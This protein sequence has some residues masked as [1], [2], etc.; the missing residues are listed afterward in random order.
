MNIRRRRPIEMRCAAILANLWNV[1][2][3]EKPIGCS[4]IGSSEACMLGGM[5]ALWRWRARR[6]AAGKPIDK[7]NLVCGP[8]QICWHKFCRYWDIEMRE[9]P[10]AP[11]KWKMDV[12]RMLEQV[13]ENTI[14]VVPTFGVTYT[15]AYEFPADIAK[16]LD[17]YEAKTGINIDI[18]VDGAS[19]AFLAPFCAPDI[20]FDFR[21]PRV[22]SISTSG[23]KYGLAPLGCGWVVWRDTSELPEGLIF[24]VNYLGGEI[25]NFA[26][27]FSRPAG[28]IICQYYDFIRLGKEGYTNIH[29]Q[30]YDV[31]QYISSE[32]AKLG[33]YEFICTGRSQGR[34]PRRL[35]L[36]QGRAKD[37]LHPLRPFRQAQDAWLAGTCLHAARGLPGYG[38][39]ARDGSPGLLQG[40]GGPLPGRLQAHDRFLRETPGHLADDR[41]RR[42]LLPPFLMEEAS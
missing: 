15:G 30:A 22:K 34:H 39:D 13:D 26:I 36:H 31:A 33:P 38:R 7:P 16:A 5:A 6:K 23:H 9:I 4:T 28:Q 8:V 27:N 2:Q 21:V 29:T 19:G 17:D 25:P 35:F 11:G 41:G 10:M 14:V 1:N 24:N 12:E 3:D 20:A 37:E 32:I 18:H 40:L 42:H